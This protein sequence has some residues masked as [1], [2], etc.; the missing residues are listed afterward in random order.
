MLIYSCDSVMCPYS[1]NTKFVGRE[2]ILEG[3][4]QQLPHEGVIEGQQ[5]A[6]TV[7]IYGLGGVGYAKHFVPAT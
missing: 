4:R 7:A 5:T 1:R 3:I 2:H 6:R